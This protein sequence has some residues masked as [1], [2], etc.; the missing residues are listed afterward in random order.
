M[1]RR[2]QRYRLLARLIDNLN[3]I[4]ALGDDALDIVGRILP[5]QSRRFISSMK[6]FDIPFNA[7]FAEATCHNPESY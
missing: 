3:P 5:P 2:G 4:A 7:G 6:A 1:I